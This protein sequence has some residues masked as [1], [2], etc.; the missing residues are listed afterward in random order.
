MTTTRTTPGGRRYTLAPAGLA[1]RAVLIDG[2]RV[3]YVMRASSRFKRGMWEYAPLPYPPG[4]IVPPQ[5]FLAGTQ[6]EAVDRLAEARES[7]FSW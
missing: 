6:G 3:G 2:D 1:Q 4:R 5:W 7:G